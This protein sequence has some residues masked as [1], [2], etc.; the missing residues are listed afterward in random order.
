MTKKSR[1]AVTQEN[2]VWQ[3]IRS[4]S[5]AFLPV[6][7]HT[8]QSI[9]CYSQCLLEPFEHHNSHDCSP[10]D[11]MRY[12][13]QHLAAFQYTQSIA[14][15]TPQLSAVQ[16]QAHLLW[17]SVCKSQSHIMGKMHDKP[18]C[19]QEGSCKGCSTR[20][21]SEQLPVRVCAIT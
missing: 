5:P 4:A 12:A 17:K 11:I 9:H 19:A 14:Q 21:H 8:F 13:I 20:A 7:A 2:P 16:F 18:I 15:S 1:R 10:H 3:A 6:C